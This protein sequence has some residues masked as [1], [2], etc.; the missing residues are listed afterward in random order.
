MTL[1]LLIALLLAPVSRPVVAT[2]AATAHGP[3]LV[4]EEVTLFDADGKAVAYVVLDEE[5]TIY[6]WSGEPV[7]Y[8]Q[9]TG[10]KHPSIYGFNGNNLGWFD[11]GVVRDHDG[12]A[13]GFVK[14]AVYKT[15]RFEPFK[16][17]KQFK[18]FKGLRELEPLE[19][20]FSLRWSST[21]LK[22]FLTQGE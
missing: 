19:P 13:V 12:D 15:T 5:M 8:I 16:S 11:S 22:E 4:A 3:R 7:A 18:P 10:R 21:P 14:G 1:A 20:L 17:F 9:R 6:L 2:L